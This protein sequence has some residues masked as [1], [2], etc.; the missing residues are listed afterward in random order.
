M[1]AGDKVV[2]VGQFASSVNDN[3]NLVRETG[4]VS[5]ATCENGCYVIWQNG[6]EEPCRHGSLRKI[7]KDIRTGRDS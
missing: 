6:Y 4:T 3:G 7:D 1:K 5:Y 2:W